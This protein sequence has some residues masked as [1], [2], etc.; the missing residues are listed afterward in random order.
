MT[1]KFGRFL[2]AHGSIKEGNFPLYTTVIAT[3]NKYPS[4]Q[5]HLD[6]SK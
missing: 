2:Q 3:D 4:D 1:R 5:V 6:K